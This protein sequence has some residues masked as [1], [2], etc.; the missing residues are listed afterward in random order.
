M[1]EQNVFH[2]E[3]VI[4]QFNKEARDLM[5]HAASGVVWLEL[6]EDGEFVPVIPDNVLIFPASRRVQ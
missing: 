3:D 5:A 1:T 4:D 2:I 6:N